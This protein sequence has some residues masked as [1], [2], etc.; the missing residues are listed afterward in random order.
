M[1][2]LF[3]RPLPWRSLVNGLEKPITALL[4]TVGVSTV[5]LAP[6]Y[7]YAVETAARGE[8]V[9]RAPMGLA[10]SQNLPNGTYLYG[11]SAE[12]E[13][14]GAA[15]MVFE[16]N[17]NQVVGAFYMPQSSFDCFYGSLEPQRMALNVIDSYERTVHPYAIAMESEASVA[18]T[19][20]EAAPVTLEG[21][22]HI[23]SISANDQRIL[24][25][26]KADINR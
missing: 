16:V 23:P 6:S 7:A 21:F 8:R 24:N 20:G 1:L 10:I 22:H 3:N 25:T 19:T 26:C 9:A 11:Q 15:Y 13:Q 4:M 2:K 14:L 18:S 17:Q 12:A 5:A